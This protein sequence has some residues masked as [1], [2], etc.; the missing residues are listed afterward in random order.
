MKWTLISSFCFSMCLL[1]ACSGNP[2]VKEQKSD[3][4]QVAM[5]GEEIYMTHCKTC[6][7]ADGTMGLSGAKNLKVSTLDKAA[8]INQVTN[9]KGMMASFKDKIS[10]EDIEKLAD[11]VLTLRK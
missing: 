6:H 5:T 7:G 8:I 1:A 4:P 2:A 11:F 10:P 3:A 9:G